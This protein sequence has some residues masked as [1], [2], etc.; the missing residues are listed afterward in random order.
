MFIKSILLLIIAILICA[1]PANSQ[2]SHEIAKADLTPYLD[3]PHPGLTPT[4]FAKD[5]L[6]KNC[7]V[8][9]NVTF[10]PELSMFSWTPNISNDSIYRGGLFIGKK[11][12]QQWLPH[13][14]ISF[15]DSLHGHRSPFFSFDGEGL[16]FQAY[17]K[18]NEGWDQFERFYYV[19]KNGDAWTR[20]ELLDTMLNKYAVHWQFS[21]D[22]QSNLYFSGDLRGIENT[23]GIYCSHYRGGKY[24]EPVLLFSNQDYGDA[25]FGPAISPEADYLLFTRIHPHDSS[26]PR[27][28]SLY[29]SFLKNNSE[30]ED[31]Q[32]MGEALKMDANQVR[33]SPDGK[34]LF[35]VGNDGHAYWVDS[36][37]LDRFR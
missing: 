29:V 26:N 20:T 24:Q 25:V 35:F 8:Y 18:A 3:Q 12:D 30:W 33:I 36:G 2:E 6:S 19:E 37:I 23:G 1:L 13:R 4:I 16:Y 27:I 7:G 14:E 32:D 17:L 9:A 15:L 10:H 5:Y 21:L 28:F 34:Y 22:K 31:P 11:H